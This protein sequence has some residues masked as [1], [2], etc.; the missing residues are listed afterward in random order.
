MIY[1]PKIVQ[2]QSIYPSNP[3]NTLQN[4][5]Q[6]AINTTFTRQLL[7]PQQPFILSN[8]STQN[9]NRPQTAH[10]QPKRRV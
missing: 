9:I 5:T 10:P 3:N 1:K 6:P 7:L 4:Q 8:Q 2:Q